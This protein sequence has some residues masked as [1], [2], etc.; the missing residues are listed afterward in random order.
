MDT[1]QFANDR[2]ADQVEDAGSGVTKERTP[3]ADPGKLYCWPIPAGGRAPTLTCAFELVYQ[4]DW[5]ELGVSE[6]AH[7]RSA[8][9]EAASQSA[10]NSPV[11]SAG[12]FCRLWPRIHYSERGQ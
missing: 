3:S 1:C 12:V 6:K 11:P 4:T 9:T 8:K 7:G 10:Q 5:S 2:I